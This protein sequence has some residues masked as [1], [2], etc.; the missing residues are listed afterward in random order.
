ML[1]DFSLQTRMKL[2]LG[3]GSRTSAVL[4]LKEFTVCQ[5]MYSYTLHTYYANRVCLHCTVC[6]RSI[7]YTQKTMILNK[8]FIERI[9]TPSF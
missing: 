7:V 1:V 5:S 3:A 9:V 2:A 6:V 4:T 8:G